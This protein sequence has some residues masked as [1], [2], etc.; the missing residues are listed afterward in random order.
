MATPTHN[1]KGGGYSPDYANFARQIGHVPKMYPSSSASSASSFLTN[2]LLPM[3]M[4]GNP[5]GTMLGFMGGRSRNKAEQASAREQ[6]AFQEHMS[7]T[8]YQR[9]MADMKKAGLNP[10]L[11][12]K[13]GGAST[14]TGAKANPVNATLQGA[15]MASAAAMAEQQVQNAKKLKMDND[16]IEEYNRKNPNAKISQQL[17]HSKPSNILWTKILERYD[18]IKILQTVE[19][20]AKNLFD[21]LKFWK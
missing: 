7:S 6:M 2:T 3:A 17:L 4:R 16:W 21:G 8:S 18:P 9:A 15:Q 14:P 19:G 20:S 5:L 1:I 13:Q 11:A 12:Y 10:I